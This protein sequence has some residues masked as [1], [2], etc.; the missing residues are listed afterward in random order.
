MDVD[1]D[2]AQRKTVR[3]DSDPILGLGSLQEIPNDILK[4][5]VLV[6]K[7]VDITEIFSPERVVKEA[8][9][10]GLSPGLSMD[11]TNG[12]DFRIKKRTDN[13]RIYM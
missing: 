7:G 4:A 13:R 8:K 9:K 11:L 12:W 6:L 1:E 3:K 2:A 10:Y 5:A